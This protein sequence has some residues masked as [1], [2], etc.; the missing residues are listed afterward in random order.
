MEGVRGLPAHGGGVQGAAALQGC[1]PA[2][3]PSPPGQRGQLEPLGFVTSSGRGDGVSN[4]LA[5]TRGS[6]LS[7]QRGGSSGLPMDKA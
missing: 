7:E 1:S 4:P 2:L 6:L 3:P 5:Q